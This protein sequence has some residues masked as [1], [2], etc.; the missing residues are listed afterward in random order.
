MPGAKILLIAGADTPAGRCIAEA[1][2]DCGHTVYACMPDICGIHQEM[3]RSLIETALVR[4]LDLHI[5]ALDVLSDESL[6]T[7]FKQVRAERRHVDAFIDCTRSRQ[8]SASGLQ[9]L[10]AAVQQLL[11]KDASTWPPDME[12]HGIIWKDLLAHHSSH[13]GS[14]LQKH[15]AKI[16]P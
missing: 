3:A 15:Y 13:G 8:I 12:Q 9:K 2:A 16:K 11:A 1:L 5:L 10:A 7:L 4:H 14:I 6:D